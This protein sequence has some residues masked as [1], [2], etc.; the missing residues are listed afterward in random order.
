MAGAVEPNKAK[1]AGSS[2]DTRTPY[3]RSLSNMQD[4]AYENDNLINVPHENT[5]EI[6]LQELISTQAQ[7]PPQRQSPCLYDYQG[8]SQGNHKRPEVLP[9]PTFSLA[10]LLNDISEERLSPHQTIRK[11]WLEITEDME[12]LAVRK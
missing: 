8:W 9:R 3:C 6:M 12:K 2:A 7:V 5:S 10:R 11:D 4:V 1:E